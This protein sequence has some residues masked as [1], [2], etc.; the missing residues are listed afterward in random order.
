MKDDSVYLQHIAD[1]IGRIRTYTNQGREAFLA[2]PMIQDAVLRNLEVIGEAV[3]RI[4]DATRQ[5]APEIPWKQIAGMRDI[6]I[7]NY[8]GVQLDRVWQVVEGD[9]TELQ[10]AVVQ[11]LSPVS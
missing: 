7:H 6:L 9:L 1:C 8:F 10:A 3:K 5:R 11:L 2:E 4:S